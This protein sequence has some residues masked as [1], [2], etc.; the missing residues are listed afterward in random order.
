MYI[1]THIVKLRNILC[2]IQSWYLDILVYISQAQILSLASQ[3][4]TLLGLEPFSILNSCLFHFFFFTFPRSLTDK[5]CSLADSPL[6]SLTD[7][8]RS[9]TDSPLSS[10]TV[11]NS[12]GYSLCRGC[13]NCL[14]VL[15]FL[16]SLMI[17]PLDIPSLPFNSYTILPVLHLL[18]G[19]F[20][21]WTMTTSPPLL[22]TLY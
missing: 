20:P 16:C 1:C 7:E 4:A 19:L 9:P 17:A 14:E 3:A 2:Y 15:S 22:M 5:L 21:L 11:V 8:L 10:P 6:H 18:W 13:F 12:K